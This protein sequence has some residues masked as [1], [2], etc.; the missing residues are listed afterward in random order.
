MSNDVS[1]TLRRN[2]VVPDYTTIANAVR[3]T[4]AQPVNAYYCWAPEP[5]RYSGG[6]ASAIHFCNDARVGRLG[7]PFHVTP[8]EFDSVRF[9]VPLSFF[10]TRLP[11]MDAHDDLYI[12]MFV[13]HGRWIARC[14]H[15]PGMYDVETSGQNPQEA[16]ERLVKK[17][18][19]LLNP[20]WYSAQF[21]TVGHKVAAQTSSSRKPVKAAKLKGVRSVAA[22]K[23]QETT[24]LTTFI[25]R[26]SVEELDAAFIT[27]K[28]YGGDRFRIPRSVCGDEW[29]EL[30]I[31]D[32]F[33]ATVRRKRT[34]EV[35]D[36]MLIG[37]VSSP[38]AMSEEQIAE[39]YVKIPAAEFK[40]AD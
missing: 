14:Q 34:G 20:M 16:A 26:A 32:W 11:N 38:E 30:D 40:Q 35:T 21:T 12:E 6:R 36:A 3:A 5:T 2:Q 29:D 10:S 24:K 15:L 7:D 28:W 9:L 22:E 17:V 37:K 4:Q 33:K 13:E 27:V 8:E 23:K 31:G 19:S 1:Q 18:E 25:I 39:I